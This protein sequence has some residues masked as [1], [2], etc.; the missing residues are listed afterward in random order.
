MKGR[1]IA[2]DYQVNIVCAP[3]TV[4]ARIVQWWLPLTVCIVAPTSNGWTLDS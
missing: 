2:D 4:V 3:L 1:A